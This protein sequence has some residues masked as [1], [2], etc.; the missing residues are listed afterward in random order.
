[1]VFVMALITF[2]FVFFFFFFGSSLL[3]DFKIKEG[4]HIHDWSVV[5]P[6]VV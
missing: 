2:N 4:E 1:M 6:T 5:L 3:I